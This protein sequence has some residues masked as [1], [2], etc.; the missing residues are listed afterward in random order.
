[1][2]TFLVLALEFSDKVV[3]K[4]VVKVLT[5]EVSVTSSRLDLEDALLDG[6]QRHI[7]GAA[8]EIEDKDVALAAVRL[9]V[10]TV[11]NGGSGGFVDDAE[12][13]KTGNQ[14]CIL[15]SLTLGVVE[16]GG[17]WRSQ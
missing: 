11:S 15:G 4:T 12:H 16:V 3:D 13:V 9:L 8:T 17:L 5:T 10:K 1:M 14:A 6:E 2:L 7:K